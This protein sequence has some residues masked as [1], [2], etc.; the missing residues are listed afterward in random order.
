MLVIKGGLQGP[1]TYFLPPCS[2]SLAIKV[3]PVLHIWELVLRV[4]SGTLCLVGLGLSPGPVGLWQFADSFHNVGRL[5]SS[6]DPRDADYTTDIIFG[7][8]DQ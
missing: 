1:S 7:N 5:I 3:C 4:F 6:H 8:L 2:S